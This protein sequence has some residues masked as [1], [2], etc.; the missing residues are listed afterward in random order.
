MR[1]ITA[2]G[3]V[4]GKYERYHKI[5]RSTENYPY[6]IQLGDFGLNMIH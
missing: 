4:H 1:S 5:V 2:I 3:D 6:T